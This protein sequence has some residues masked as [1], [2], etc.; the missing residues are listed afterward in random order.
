MRPSLADRFLTFWWRRGWRG[1][2][3]LSRLRRSAGGPGRLLLRT[4]FGSLFALDPVEYIDGIVLREGYY[5]S[6]VIAALRPFLGA[7][8]T[9]WDIGANFGLHSITVKCLEPS[10]RVIAFEPNP[11]MV[12]ELESNCRLNGVEVA[13]LPL[14][15][16][17]SSGQATLHISARGNSGM[18]TLRVW[19]GGRY[20][21]QVVVECQRGDELVAAC[22]VPP[23]TVIKM[24]V[25][26]SE[27]AVLSGLGALL[28]RPEL[29]AIVFEADSD[30][31]R[32]PD[33]DPLARELR[34]SGFSFTSLER[35]EQS[36]HPLANFLAIRRA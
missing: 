6:E 21:G 35:R 36:A 30:L 2:H 15:L 14:A 1:F 22:A 26:G 17:D 5:E 10:T 33:A 12:A 11:V 16:A 27:A 29:R 19:S 34:A 3:F 18:S 20:E 25:E 24:D 31:E 9:L 7:G 32:E 23:P 13:I 4:P 28:R 8:S